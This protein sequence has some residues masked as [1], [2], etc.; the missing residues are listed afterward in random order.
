VIYSGKVFRQE[1]AKKAFP[2]DRGESFVYFNHEHGPPKSRCL[3]VDV[4]HKPTSQ[5][6]EKSV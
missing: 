6:H 1:N 5:F 4:F 2:P 3:P